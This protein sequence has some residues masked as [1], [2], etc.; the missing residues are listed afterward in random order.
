MKCFHID[1]CI[2]VKID[3]DNYLKLIHDENDGEYKWNKSP[4]YS[5]VNRKAKYI[6]KHR[7]WEIVRIQ[8]KNLK[9]TYLS[10]NDYNH[11]SYICYAEAINN[12]YNIIKQKNK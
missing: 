4:D 9:N 1:I 5:I 12:V 7:Q 6:K 11:P 2:T 10:Q 8:Y 3:K